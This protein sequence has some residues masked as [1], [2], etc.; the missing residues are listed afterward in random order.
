LADSVEDKGIDLC[1][2]FG[3]FLR[4][5]M[6]HDKGSGAAV[7]ASFRESAGWRVNVHRRRFTLIHEFPWLAE[8]RFNY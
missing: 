2:R 7:T 8:A 3:I 5:V 4:T 1:C 6:I